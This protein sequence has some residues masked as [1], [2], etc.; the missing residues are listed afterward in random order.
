MCSQPLVKPAEI[1]LI[2]MVHQMISDGNL[3]FAQLLRNALVAK[4]CKQFVMTLYRIA[5][6]WL[7]SYFLVLTAQPAPA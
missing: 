5:A 2:D 6:H 7:T 3:K 1:K 4:V